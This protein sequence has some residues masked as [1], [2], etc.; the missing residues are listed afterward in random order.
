MYGFNQSETAYSLCA[1]WCDD[2]ALLSAL[3][4]GTPALYLP[5]VCLERI[6]GVA[7]E[8]VGDDHGEEDD[9]CACE[10]HQIEVGR[11][12][13]APDAREDYEEGGVADASQT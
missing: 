13:H 10:V 12:A 4:Y 3:S 11:C 7:D 5:V 8:L 6:N 1:G 9:V 2:I